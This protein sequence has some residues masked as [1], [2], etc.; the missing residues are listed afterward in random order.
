MKKTKKSR[1]FIKYVFKY[2]YI[3][4]LGFVALLFTNWFQLEIPQNISNITLYFK[5]YSD[6]N[7]LDQYH[8]YDVLRT[9]I[10]NSFKNI[11]LFASIV[12]I[13]RFTWRACFLNIGRVIESKIREELFL[14]S[15]KQSQEFYSTNKV[16]N[17]MALYTNDLSSVRASFSFG[18]VT[19]GDFIILGSLTLYKMFMIN[20]ILG[21]IASIPM[22]FGGLIYSYAYK[23]IDK[24]WTKVQE[25]F[26]DISDFAQ[27]SFSGMS[28]IKA[29]VQ[30]NNFQKHFHKKIRKYYK[31]NISFVK[32]NT[33][34]MVLDNFVVNFIFALVILIGSL[35]VLGK[36]GNTSIH[37]EDI[38]HFL[39]LFNILLW[40]IFALPE[41]L[42]MIT[43]AHASAKRISKYLDSDISV[44]DCKNPIVV[45]NNKVDSSINIKNLW[46]KY[47]D[48]SEDDPY[49]LKDISLEIKPGQLVGIIGKT[50][51]G[52]TTLIDI[53]LRLYNIEE[54]KVF[55]G[56]YDIMKL[57]IKQVREN[58]SLVPQDNFLFSDTISENI[59]FSNSKLGQ[60]A[61]ENAAYSAGIYDNIIQFPDKFQTVLG[62]RGVT[63]SGGQ[64]QRI[65]IARALA[66]NS[67]V[68]ILDDSVSAVDTK[69]EELIIN[70]L[71]QLRE[72]RSVILVAHRIS[73][74]KKM[75]KIILLDKGS[76]IAQGTHSQLLETSSEYQKLV[77]LQKLEE[78]D[79]YDK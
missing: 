38:L 34:F 51:C 1:H 18:V 52:K 25:S 30:Q 2:W 57:P 39:I 76:I 79:I 77:K 5:N 26:A 55:L 48:S 60:K 58:I 14:K 37:S 21:L 49:L 75:D 10:F 61:V 4:L 31:D 43:Q 44:K 72:N 73:T 66:K 65:S 3:Y 54:N 11:L 53:L 7:I 70:N 16:G 41:F 29:F 35:I 71:L 8:N 40:P 13:G 56:G 19:L 32:S 23:P 47:P 67:K 42:S 17:I 33:T 45:E 46:F 9:N 22:L 63:V 36:I 12:V 69:T 64:K 24:K 78:E 50:G 74:I 20:W 28:V 27:E 6:P 15:T 62:E 59:S 68:L